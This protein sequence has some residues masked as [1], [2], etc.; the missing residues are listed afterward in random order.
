MII[1]IV[2]LI[3]DTNFLKTYSDNGFKI[4]KIGTSEIYD[5][6]ID[7]IDTTFLYE[8]IDELVEVFESEE[9]T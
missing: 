9:V 3:H 2:E 8:E 4:R 1:R 6:A 5:E 7:I